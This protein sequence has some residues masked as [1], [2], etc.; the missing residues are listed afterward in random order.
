[1]PHGSDFAD[2][3]LTGHLVVVDFWTYCCIN[4]MHVMP[5]LKKLENQFSDLITIGVHSSKFTN[6]KSRANIAHAMK[7]HRISHPVVCDTDLQVWQDMEIVCW[8]TLL[9][10]N[11]QGLVIGEFQGE[12]QANS[13]PRFISVC[14]KYYK[15]SLASRTELPQVINQ[16]ILNEQLDSDDHNRLK[17]PT[18][19]VVHENTLFISDSGN[20]RIVLV[21]VRTNKIKLV[22]GSGKCGCV[23]SDFSGSS[24]DWPQGLA[25]DAG[26]NI[27]Y[28]AD[29][30]NDV[31]RAA[32]LTRNIVTTVCGVS[33]KGGN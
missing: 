10:V 27:L 30:F 21:D 8:P 9:V 33:N 13:V 23:D 1:V 28:I 19:I 12:I 24:F 14:F 32:D 7:R 16:P 6:E 3:V 22:I 18:K 2:A 5:L 25:Y 26:A 20:N 4:C 15:S 17:F 31:V 29:T 11:P